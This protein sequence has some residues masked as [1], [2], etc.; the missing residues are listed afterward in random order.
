MFL[1][2]IIIYNKEFLEQ[3][4]SCLVEVGILNT[5]IISTNSLE[6]ELADNVPL[7]AGLKFNMENKTHTKIVL[8]LID[9]EK[10]INEINSLLLESGIDI[11]KEKIGEIFTIPISSAVGRQIK[12]KTNKKK[13]KTINKK[14]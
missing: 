11:T 1:L 13:V 7:F 4:L 10:I 5:F 14:L 2:I 9:N 3:F 6:E 8:S 12:S